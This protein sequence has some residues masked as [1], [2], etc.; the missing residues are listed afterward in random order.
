LQY[1]GR[2]NTHHQRF[3]IGLRFGQKF[4]N[5]AFCSYLHLQYFNWA[6]VPGGRFSN[7]P[8]SQSPIV[9]GNFC[10]E[11]HNFL[12]YVMENKSVKDLTSK[13]REKLNSLSY[14]SLFEIINFNDDIVICEKARQSLYERLMTDFLENYLK[15]DFFD[16]NKN[17]SF[18]IFDF[19]KEFIN[20]VSK[21]KGILLGHLTIDSSETS[22]RKAWDNIDTENLQFNE[23][24]TIICDCK[25]P[26]I[27]EEAWDIFMEKVQYGLGIVQNTEENEPFD[28]LCL[29][30]FHCKNEI[31]VSECWRLLKKYNFSNDTL[32]E[33]VL[34][35]TNIS[36]VEYAWKHLN[37]SELKENE[38]IKIIKETKNKK[39]AHE[40]L[41]IFRKLKD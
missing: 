27:Q 36:I 8:T 40:A 1:W 20:D 24:S 28:S 6:A 11:H 29:I 19:I 16:K 12:K 22:S 41:D 14:E 33:I 15:D 10:G 38:I 3:A 4:F 17:Q 32:L 26:S 23:L 21:S 25:Y 39:V 2:S 13:N 9:G 34:E 31:F 5:V 7:S 18:E 35:N 37:T 30:C